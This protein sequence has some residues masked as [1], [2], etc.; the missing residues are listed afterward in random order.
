MI[1]K[2]ANYLLSSNF[3]NQQNIKSDA[4]LKTNIKKS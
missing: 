2:K 3:K 4:K 1:C